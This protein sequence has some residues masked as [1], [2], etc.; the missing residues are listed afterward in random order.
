LRRAEAACQHEP[1]NDTYL[2]TLGVA[3]YRVGLLREAL[4]TLR[5][6]NALSGGSDPA[7]LAFLA[8]AYQRLEQA[9]QARQTLAGLRFVG[10]APPR[11]RAS[12]G[13]PPFLREAG[14]LIELDPAFPADPF[15]R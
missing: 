1:N 11:N 13:T 3:Q 8:M 12:T 15:G 6:S 4:A 9:E 14:V 10:R 2:N 7:N 5:R